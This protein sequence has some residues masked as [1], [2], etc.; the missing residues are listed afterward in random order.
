MTFLGT[1]VRRHFAPLMIG[2]QVLVDLGVVLVACG[3]AYLFGE[4]IGENAALV[5]PWQVYQEVWVLMAAICLVSFHAFGMYRPTKSLLNVEE[6]K[7]I[8]KSTVVAFLAFFTTMVLL[9]STTQPAQ[10]TFYGFLVPL[11]GWVELNMSIDSYSRVTLVSTFVFVLVLTTVSRF[12]SFKFIQTLYRRGIGNRNVLI[13]GT[14][15]TG[16]ALQRKFLIVP[17][18]GLRLVGFLSVE[19]DEVGGMIEGCP[20]LG[21]FDELAQVVGD[22]KVNEVFVAL[23][24]SSEEDLMDLIGKIEGMGVVYRVVP[25][26]YHLLA[27]RVRIDYL[28]SM[29]LISRPVRRESAVGA[30]AKRIFDL[31]LA[32]LVLV[33]SSPMFLAAA[34]LIRRESP[35]KVLYRQTRVGKDGRPFEMLKF[36]TMYEHMGGDAPAPRSE[37]DPRITRVGKWLR[38]YSLDEIPQ[39]I[40]VLRGEMSIV[41]PRPEMQFIVEQYTPM[42]QER[43]R[44]KPGITG[45]WQISYARE[46]AIHENI[47]YDIYYIENQSLLLDIVIIALTFAAVLK[48]TGAH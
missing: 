13:F 20:V 16:R 1:F 19:P 31:A 27:Q 4:R 10:G 35:G 24:Q 30:F 40:N 28:D 36:R 25:R 41:G 34:L 17:N 29:P 43:L 32:S 48:G 11:H 23:P 21:T 14:G 46:E 5:P 26:F 38:R 18:L 45:L 2:A 44:A 22:Q 37:S 39:F 3:M 7:A 33:L 12:V 8:L 15:Q 47:D 9:R 42:V 6:F